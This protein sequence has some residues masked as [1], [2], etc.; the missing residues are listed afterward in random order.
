M[1]RGGHYGI[2]VPVPKDIF[3]SRWTRFYKRC[4]RRRPTGVNQADY[5]RP[6]YQPN[7]LPDGVP[8]P[9]KLQYSYENFGTGSEPAEYRQTGRRVYVD[10]LLGQGYLR[11][12]TQ[13]NSPEARDLVLRA[14]DPVRRGGGHSGY[15]VVTGGFAQGNSAE[16]RIAAPAHIMN[17]LEGER[18]SVAG[19]AEGLDPANHGTSPFV[20]KRLYEL[21]EEKEIVWE[22]G[23]DRPEDRKTPLEMRF[24]YV[25]EQASLM[26]ELP[27]KDILRFRH[28]TKS[29]RKPWWREI[30]FYRKQC[31]RQF[32]RRKAMVE[33][34]EKARAQMAQQSVASK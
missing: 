24:P 2:W 21:C 1:P 17:I 4:Y 14:L 30:Q 19:N 26:D 23:Q 6:H 12:Y 11:P 34:E 16:A 9:W 31:H 33:L 10:S 28:R 18:T 13:S 25:D 8:S 5:G 32:L 27:L 7:I 29:R 22:K 15:G 20:L 3:R